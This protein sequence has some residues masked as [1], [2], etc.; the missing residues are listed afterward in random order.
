LL[1]LHPRAVGPLYN[2]WN[3]AG[4]ELYSLLPSDSGV[5]AA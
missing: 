4:I 5:G 2:Q 1:R 3:L